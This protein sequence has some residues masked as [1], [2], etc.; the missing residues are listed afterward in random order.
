MAFLKK[1]YDA[2]N[3]NKDLPFTARFATGYAPGSTFKTIT[4]A[5]GLDAGTLKPDE[6]LEINGL[7]WQKDKSWGGYFCDTCKK[8]Q[9]QSICVPLL[10][11][12]DN[13]YFAQQTLR[14]GKTNLERVLINSFSVRN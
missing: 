2:Y 10:V 12:S 3:N 14:M 5:I 4:G 8:K 13:I 7:K 1:E 11:N 6:E 9:V